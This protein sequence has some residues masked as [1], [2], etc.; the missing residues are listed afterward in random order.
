[1][2]K[3]VFGITVEKEESIFVDTSH[4]LRIEIA[5]YIHGG[6]DPALIVLNLTSEG[7]IFDVYEPDTTDNYHTMGIE[8]A[9][10]CPIEEGENE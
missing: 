2:S 8:W 7:I 4:P 6:A 5:S 1:M 3:D 10:F 9:D